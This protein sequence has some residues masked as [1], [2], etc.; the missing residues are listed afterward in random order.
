VVQ[1]FFALIHQYVIRSPSPSPF[2]SILGHCA[3]AVGKYILIYGGRNYQED[4]MAEG[5]YLFD[6]EVRSWERVRASGDPVNPRTGHCAIPSSSGII[7]FG[8]LVSK[9]SCCSEA[10]HLDMF[11]VFPKP[12]FL[13][14][15]STAHT[16]SSNRNDNKTTRVDNSAEQSYPHDNCESNNLLFPRTLIHLIEL[17]RKILPV[18]LPGGSNSSDNGLERRAG[19]LT[20]NEYPIADSNR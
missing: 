13:A 3:V 10:V 2:C 19:Y 5:I 17:F 14:N 8:G 1:P 18:R 7:F 6:T 11:G 16:T 12:V 15:K 4:T 9:T 20:I